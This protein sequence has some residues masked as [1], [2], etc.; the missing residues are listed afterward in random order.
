MLIL[1]DFIFVNWDHNYAKINYFILFPWHPLM[2]SWIVN[3]QHLFFQNYSYVVFSLVII[4][5]SQQMQLPDLQRQVKY[6]DREIFLNFYKNQ[7][8]N[9]NKN[10]Y[11][12]KR[13]YFLYY[14]V[15]KNIFFG[16]WK[17][18]RNRITFSYS[19]YM[20]LQFS[21]RNRSFFR[22]SDSPSFQRCISHG[23][24]F[25]QMCCYADLNSTLIML[26]TSPCTLYIG[27]RSI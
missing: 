25:C 26:W 19:L 23:I 14:W 27:T 16:E 10:I 24:S 3:L 11:R 4:Y 8:I 13:E 17:S 20:H 18:R 7:D 5:S 21:S 9:E 12:N 2:M 15:N 1:V 6:R 22:S